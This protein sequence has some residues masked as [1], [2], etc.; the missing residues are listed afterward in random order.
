MATVSRSTTVTSGVPLIRTVPR[1]T[2][3]TIVIIFSI[4]TLILLIIAVVMFYL[5][6]KTLA[7]L[8]NNIQPVCKAAV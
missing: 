4:I 2:V 3:I 7:N 8:Q 1:T 5:Y 6:R